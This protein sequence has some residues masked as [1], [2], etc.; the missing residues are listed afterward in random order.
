MK[1]N[2][3]KEKELTEKEKKDIEEGVKRLIEEHGDVLNRLA[4][5]D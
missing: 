2:K 5:E 4:N 1:K 3:K